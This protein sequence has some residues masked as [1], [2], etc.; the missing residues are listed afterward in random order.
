[1]LNALTIA[2]VDPTSAQPELKAL[3]V[4]LEPMR[5]RD[6]PVRRRAPARPKRL[7]VV[8]T[9]MAGLAVVEE[10]LR[11][12][13]AS[14]WRIVML[15]EEP[16]PSY[17][18]VLLSKLLARTCGPGE[19]ELRTLS[20]YAAHRVDLRGGCRADALDL[21]GRAVIDEAGIRHRYDALVLATGSRAFVPPI[22]GADL[23]HVDVFRTWRD[24]D[25]LAATP[26]GARAVV[27]GGGLLGLEAAAGLR[28]RGVEVTVVEL[29]EQLMGQQ[30]DAGAAAMLQRTLTRQGMSCRLGRG[31]ARIE[32]DRVVLDDGEELP[33]TRVVVAAGIRPEV[34]LARAAGLPVQRGIVVDDTLRAGA[35]SVWAV[36]EC[37]EHR[38]VVYGLWSPLAEQARVAGAGVAGDP[39]AFRGAA[40]A[41]MLKVS[42]VDV[43]AGGVSA[44]TAPAGHDEIVASDTRRGVFRRLV[45]DGERLVGAALVGDVG[46]ARQLSDLLRTGEPVPSDLLASGGP[47]GASADALTADPDA[48]LC[49]CNAVSVGDVQ[50]AIRR[51]GLST[52]AQVGLRT[53]ATTGCGGCTADVETLL[54]AAAAVDR[55]RV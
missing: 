12:R 38:G 26:P 4:R 11:R 23:P 17:N 3:A 44:G 27:V 34:S 6:A 42:G 22:P 49:S 40:L 48:T 7:V 10:A 43:Y 5:R 41:T 33:A 39:G 1:V 13:P 29:A 15:G 20:W 32:P 53:R 36:G 9:G 46:A 55:L 35:P 31:A 50:A 54:G 19:L 25:A 8:G 18:R 45:L 16:G 28:A 37:A 14:H 21:D 2:A 52:V 51:D 24:A 30:L 47:G